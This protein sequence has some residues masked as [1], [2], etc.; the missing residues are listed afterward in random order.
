MKI[1]FPHFVCIRNVH[2]W[3]LRYDVDSYHQLGY[4]W[5]VI[6]RKQC[7]FHRTE[8]AFER[9]HQ[10]RNFLLILYLNCQKVLLVNCT[11]YYYRNFEVDTGLHSTHIFFFLS[12]VWA[13]K[14][15]LGHYLSLSMWRVKGLLYLHFRNMSSYSSKILPT[16]QKSFMGAPPFISRMLTT[17]NICLIVMVS[18][19]IAILFV[20]QEL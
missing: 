16:I 12:Y 1:S 3:S 2:I 18:S 7:V 11:T 13:S 10:I 9:R 8:T 15:S 5:P 20:K 6:H 19:K 14:S 4:G 17:S